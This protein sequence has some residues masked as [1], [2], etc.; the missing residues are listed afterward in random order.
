VWIYEVTWG[1]PGYSC[2]R[3]ATT[4]EY[5]PPLFWT[6]PVKL[7]LITYQLLYDATAR[8]GFEQVGV[9]ERAPVVL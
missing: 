3:V 2:M 9:V 8:V 4:G 1:I 6:R 5:T 7:R